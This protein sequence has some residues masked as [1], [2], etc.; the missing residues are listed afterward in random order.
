MKLLFLGSFLFYR[1]GA[2][3]WKGRKA[4]ANF[5]FPLRLCG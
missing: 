3:I 1:K 2:K 5:G 4:L